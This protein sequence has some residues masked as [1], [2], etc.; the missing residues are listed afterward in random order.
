[1]TRKRI[2]LAIAIA[3][4]I[5]S[6]LPILAPVFA[7]FHFDFAAKPIY[8]IYQWFCH[9]RPWRSFHIFDYQYALDSRMTLIFWSMA[10]AGYF[11]YFGRIKPVRGKIILLFCVVMVLPLVID[12]TVQAVA[13]ALI[14]NSAKIPFYESTNLTRGITGLLLGTGIGFS[15]FPYLQSRTV[16]ASLSPEFIKS[17]VLS[18]ITS[19]IL[20]PVFVF[21]WS[22]TSEVYLPGSLFIDFVSRIPGYSYEI[23]EGGG[24]SPYSR[25]IKTGEMRLYWARA[26]RYN[27]TDLLNEFNQE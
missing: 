26:K 21:F 17:F 16:V 14:Y 20:I 3:L 2:V 4:T 27:K 19:F 7:H 8:W 18:V 6:L 22:L 25:T 10:I 12:G 15:L 23:T 5:I 13:E 9:Q 1:M 11:V 24:H